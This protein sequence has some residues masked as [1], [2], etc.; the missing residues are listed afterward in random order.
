MRVVKSVCLEVI[1]AQELG[2]SIPR[3]I[4]EKESQGKVDVV[5][6]TK[7]AGPMPQWLDKI[8][9]NI[10]GLFQTMAAYGC[11]LALCQR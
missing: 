1:K 3:E 2:E 11:P 10:L 6:M 5:N 7:M 4:S 9:W 8:Q